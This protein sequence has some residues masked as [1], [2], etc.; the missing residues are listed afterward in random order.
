V[1]LVI[2]EQALFSE[3]DPQEKVTSPEKKQKTRRVEI[4]AVHAGLRKS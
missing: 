1:G 4:V 2:V 3:H